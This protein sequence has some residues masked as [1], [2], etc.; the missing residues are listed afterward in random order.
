[1][2]EANNDNILEVDNISYSVREK[3]IIED[4]SFQLEK[5]GFY[6]VIG[7]NGSGKTT[8]LKLLIIIFLF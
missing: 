1:M 3:N 7:T 8:L 4:I 6:S 2:Q 5:G